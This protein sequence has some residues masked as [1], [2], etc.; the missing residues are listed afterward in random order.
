MAIEKKGYKDSLVWQKGTQLAK[1]VYRITEILPSEE[2]FGLVSQMR[3][4][5]VS[6]PSNVAEGQARHTK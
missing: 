6:I 4:A 3:Q 2:R 1:K 5:A